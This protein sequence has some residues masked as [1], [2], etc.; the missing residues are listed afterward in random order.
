MDDLDGSESEYG[1]DGTR[2]VML[3]RVIARGGGASRGSWEPRCLK[4]GRIG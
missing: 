3:S 2:N 1:F 4:S